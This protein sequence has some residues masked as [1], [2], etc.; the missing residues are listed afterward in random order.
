M[1][2]EKAVQGISEQNR[3]FASTKYVDESGAWYS[4]D[5]AGI[6]M[7]A[8]T[9]NRNTG[10]FRFELT[11][12][13]EPDKEVLS[14]A[15][16]QTAA[17]FPYFNVSLRRGFFWYYLDQC[18]SSPP[19]YSDEDQPC[20]EWNINRPGTRMF[21]VRLTGRR[22]VG[23]FSHALTDGSGGISF[24]KSLLVRYFA[25]MGVEPG[26][27]LGQGEW[28]DIVDPDSQVDPEEFEDGYQKFFP[29]TLPLPE[30]NP[31]AW[32]MKGP[33]LAP[34]RYRI[35]TGTLGLSSVLAE[36]KRRGIT[37]TEFLG[38]IYLDALQDLWFNL[39]RKPK[40]HFISLEIPVNLRQFFATNTKKNFSLFILIQENLH[41]GRRDF[42]EL[43]KRT[44]YHM[45]LEYDL[46]SIARQISRNAGGTRNWAV[47][48]VP[49]FAKDFFARILFAKLGE[50]MLSG[51]ISNL[52]AVKLPAPIGKEVESFAF[53]PAPS[54]TTLVNA[55]VVSWKDALVVSF[56][57]L[58]VSR[59][60]ETLFF[61]KLKDL[62]LTASVCCRDDEE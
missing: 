61:R 23:E 16:A 21:R 25:L 55:S 37:I 41:L 31:R 30:P 27:E 29:G 12:K 15:L 33:M 49:L 19:L 34:G 51:F 11:L 3:R 18:A 60:L 54:T 9:D 46:K 44:H 45:R 14:R 20:Q 32:H 53:V 48:A 24:M 52:G 6:I 4:L 35:I 59:D 38:A 26:V 17:R 57:S 28:S 10:L 39:P 40:D 2:D 56:G 8:V 7:P 43:V 58:A 50:T 22:L 1:Y 42:A 36:A 13:A 5:N 62:G 47:R